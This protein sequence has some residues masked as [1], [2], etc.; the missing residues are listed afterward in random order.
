M[1][2]EEIYHEMEETLGT[3]PHCARK[4]PD[5]FLEQ[6]WHLWNRLRMTDTCIP[7]KEKAL[8]SLG[9]SAANHDWMGSMMHAEFAKAF[10]ATEDELREVA[11]LAKEGVGWVP[12]ISA[13]LVTEEAV[14][15]DI[16]TIASHCKQEAQ[17][18]AA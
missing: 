16:Q 10:G 9:I 11:Y 2:R 4:T 1:T 6:D 8:V 3:V 18:R 14:K 13:N 7:H 12:F 17:R 15:E 5:E